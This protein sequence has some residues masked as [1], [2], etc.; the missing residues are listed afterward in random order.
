MTQKMA[1][2]RVAASAAPHP[3]K[4]DGS[5]TCFADERRLDRRAQKR[6]VAHKSDD[7]PDRKDG[8][9]EYKEGNIPVPAFHRFVS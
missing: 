6:D 9:R 1:L 3:E 8:T 2:Y 7:T 5:P 4:M